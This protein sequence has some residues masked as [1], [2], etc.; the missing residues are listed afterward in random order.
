V[1]TDIVS[2]RNTSCNLGFSKWRLALF[3]P[4]RDIELIE[5]HMYLLKKTHLC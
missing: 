5:K 2:E 4:N 3:V 1:K